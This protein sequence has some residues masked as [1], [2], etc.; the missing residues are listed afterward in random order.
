MVITKNSK[1]KNTEWIKPRELIGS[2]VKP[3]YAPKKSFYL[4][5]VTG[6]EFRPAENKPGI[7]REYCQIYW[8]N[9]LDGSGKISEFQ[10]PAEL[11]VISKIE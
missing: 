9:Q 5:L 8:M 6:V 4:G 1:K 3:K 2:L 10:D 7:Y 11:E